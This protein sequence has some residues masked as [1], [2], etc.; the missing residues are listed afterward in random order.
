MSHQDD[1]KSM[2]ESGIATAGADAKGLGLG[3]DPSTPDPRT[4]PGPQLWRRVAIVSL[5]GLIVLCTGW[6]LAW[7]PLRPGGSWLVLK[8]L[9][10]LAMLP[11]L[12]KSRLYSYQWASMAI[13]L[14]FME[15][16][17][18]ATSDVNPTSVALAWTETALSTLMFCALLMYTKAFKRPKQVPQTD[19]PA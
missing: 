19:Q 12:L 7:A 3:S 8:V 13:L 10:L 18:R 16:T 1:A 11:G 14:Y 6:E 15:G 17:V 4:L 9:P 5:L 2:N